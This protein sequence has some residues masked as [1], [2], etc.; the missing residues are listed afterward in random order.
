VIFIFGRLAKAGNVPAAPNIA[1]PAN[2]L[3]K[4]RLFME[5]VISSWNSGSVHQGTVSKTRDVKIRE[6]SGSNSSPAF[7]RPVGGNGVPVP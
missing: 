5:E 2:D 4:V 7:Q 3:M 6:T 1:A